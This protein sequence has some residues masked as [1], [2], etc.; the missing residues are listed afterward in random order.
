[1][2]VGHAKGRNIVFPGQELRSHDIG[3]KSLTVV[4]VVN[5]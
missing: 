5:G 3:M 4:T 2:P 1:M